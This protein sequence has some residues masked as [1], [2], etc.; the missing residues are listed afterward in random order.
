[1]RSWV[2][3]RAA[4]TAR[5]EHRPR[6]RQQRGG[7]PLVAVLLLHAGGQQDFIN[8]HPIATKRVLRAILK[9]ADLCASQPAW[10]AER[11]VEGRFTARTIMHSRR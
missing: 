1:M 5:P 10:V 8:K 2:P 4:G 9:A 3:A 6:D 7:P 11:L